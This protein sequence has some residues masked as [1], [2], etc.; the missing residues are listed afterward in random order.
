MLSNKVTNG[1]LIATIATAV[2]TVIFVLIFMLGPNYPIQGADVSVIEVKVE[3]GSETEIE[4]N[5]LEFY[6]GVAY[7]Y[8]IKLKSKKTAEFEISF[9]FTAEEMSSLSQYVKVKIIDSKENVL[10]DKLVKDAIEDE[11]FVVEADLEKNVKEDLTVIYYMEHTV[12]NEAKNL[13]LTLD[14]VIT[15]DEK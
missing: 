5:E 11:A 13:E 10:Y 6:P 9:D 14:L 15:I 12:G 1:I 3:D 2:L 7:D 4:F 8:T